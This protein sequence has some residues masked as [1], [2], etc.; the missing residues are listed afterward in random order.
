MAVAMRALDAT[1]VTLRPDGDTRRIS[2][3]EFYRLPGDTPHIET[4]LEHG[5]LITHV[6]LPPNP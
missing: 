5:E 3:H 4:A 6:E 2:I 1:I